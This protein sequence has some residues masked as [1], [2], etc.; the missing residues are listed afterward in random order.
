MIGSQGQQISAALI[1]LALVV[2]TFVIFNKKYVSE[3]VVWVRENINWYL[4]IM[5]K[6]WYIQGYSLSNNFPL[7]VLIYFCIVITISY[8]REFDKFQIWKNFEIFI[9]KC[10]PSNYFLY[11]LL[12]RYSQ[13]PFWL[14]VGLGG[15]KSNLY[16]WFN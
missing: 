6:C 13:F 16:T 11:L 5:Y 3:Y 15:V 9:A 12:F 8:D 7:K 2:S 4:D 10:I 1:F 14:S